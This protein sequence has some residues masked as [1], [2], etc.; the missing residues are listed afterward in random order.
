[1]ALTFASLLP[2]A[3]FGARRPI[4]AHVVFSLH[5]YAFILLLFCVSLLAVELDFVR[6]GSGLLYRPLDILVSLL[7]LAVASTY[8]H[9]SVKAV[10][11]G[12]GVIAFCRTAILAVALA[13]IVLGYRFAIFLITLYL[14]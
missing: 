1:M 13:A 12:R 5:L 4:G 10:Y 7:N 11:G 3:F 2:W 8:L 6:G 9:I 14:T